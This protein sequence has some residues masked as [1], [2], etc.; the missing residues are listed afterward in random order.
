M[1]IIMQKEKPK[2]LTI[3]RQIIV[4]MELNNNP[5]DHEDLMVKK[6]RKRLWI[7]CEILGTRRKN[8]NLCSAISNW[9]YLQ[10]INRAT[11]KWI[12]TLQELIVILLFVTRLFKTRKRTPINQQADTFQ[13]LI[14]LG[15]K[16]STNSV[17]SHYHSS[18]SS[19]RYSFPKMHHRRWKEHRLFTITPNH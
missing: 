19:T 4:V 3:I 8:C 13:K 16:W 12:I 9:K 2:I 14:I 10:L 11:V 17:T 6:N 7:T 15:H 1:H 18:L 5:A